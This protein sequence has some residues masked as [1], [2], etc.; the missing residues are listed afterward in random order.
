MMMFWDSFNNTAVAVMQV[1]LLAGVGF[2]LVKKNIINEDGL[3]V[4]SRLLVEVTMPVLIFCQLIKGFS[5]SIYPNWWIFPLISIV[6]TLAGFGVGAA[7]LKVIKEKGKKIQFLSLVSFQN[8]GY[9]PMALITTLPIKA[10]MADTL[11]IYLFL[12][13]LGFNLV[14]WSVGVYLLTA[15]RTA[16]FELGSLFSPPV[17]ATLL[18]LL[19]I[20]LKVQ[21][22]IPEAFVKSLKTLGDCTVPLAMVIVGGNLAMVRLSHVDAKAVGWIVFLK[23]VLLP[24]LGILLINWLKLPYL[25][26]LLIILELCMPP[27]TSLSVIIRHYKKEDLLI[28][29]G[30]FFGHMIS[31]VTIPLFLSLY[32]VNSMI[33]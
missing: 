16:R 4:L 27:A 31:V 13:L 6:I 3:N 15:K 26:G 12:F 7:F 14:I 20:S 22:I 18:S 10:G 33:Q 24:G 30:V 5:F 1:L 23:N 17:I 9:L 19:L 25:L 32:F 21:Y 11:F 2:F 8:S 28:S 29:Q